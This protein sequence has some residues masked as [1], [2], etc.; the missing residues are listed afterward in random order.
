MKL[1]QVALILIVAACLIN[2]VR[3]G[4]GFHHIAEVLPFASG[5]RPGIYDIGSIILL[6]MGWRGFQRLKQRYEDE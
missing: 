4:N 6:A 3:Q 1:F 2:W 5:H